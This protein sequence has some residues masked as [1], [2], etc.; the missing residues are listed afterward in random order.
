MLGFELIQNVA[1]FE[2]VV[3]GIVIIGI[4][5]LLMDYF[6]LWSVDDVKS[7]WG[8]VGATM[9]LAHSSSIAFGGPLF[10]KPSALAPWVFFVFLLIVL[11]EVKTSYENG[12]DRGRKLG[13]QEGQKMAYNRVSQLVEESSEVG[14]V[15]ERV[16]EW[17]ERA[18]EDLEE[19]E[20]EDERF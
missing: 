1:Y 14:E 17:F 12:E 6:G 11:V 15:G 8:V 19:L 7:K 10:S 20:E 16:D 3:S 2:G 13:V 5:I 18:E 9:I 4:S